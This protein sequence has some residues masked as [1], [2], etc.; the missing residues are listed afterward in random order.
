MQGLDAPQ[1]DPR[2]TVTMV[3]GVVVAVYFL[4]M[5]AWRLWEVFK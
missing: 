4:A 3:I 2:G 1:K 5:V